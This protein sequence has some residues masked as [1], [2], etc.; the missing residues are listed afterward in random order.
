[1]IT[2]NSSVNRLELSNL[3]THIK[4]LTVNTTTIIPKYLN[5]V[6]R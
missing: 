1:M 2:K 3:P 5:K 4:E 6:L